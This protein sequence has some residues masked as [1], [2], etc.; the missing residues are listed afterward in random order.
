MLAQL[1]PPA[2]TDDSRP[3]S[4]FSDDYYRDEQRRFTVATLEGSNVDSESSFGVNETGMNNTLQPPPT[5]TRRRHSRQ[6]RQSHPLAEEYQQIS[7]EPKESSDYQRFV[8]QALDRDRQESNEMWR[9]AITRPENKNI[10][11]I[12]ADHLNS[13]SLQRSGTFGAGKKERSASKKMDDAWKRSSHYSYQS[14]SRKRRSYNIGGDNDLNYES[15]SK[16]LR[17]KT[18]GAKRLSD[19]FK[20]PR[21]VITGYEQPDNKRLSRATFR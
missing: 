11:P 3:Q 1:S 19:Y 15:P 20:P 13:S 10:P 8:Q 9:A 7:E 12:H 17:K 5:P 16:D 21:D 14:D 18:T 6:K 2:E 4:Y